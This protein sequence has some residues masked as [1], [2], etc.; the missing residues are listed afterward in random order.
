MK[1]FKADRIVSF[2]PRQIKLFLSLGFA[3]IKADTGV[4]LRILASIIIMKKFF[5]LKP[6]SKVYFKL[7]KS[8]KRINLEIRKVRANI[9]VVHNYTSFE[10]VKY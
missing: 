8:L 10:K 9:P 7:F 1:M 3:V 5:E 4:F 2:S 6:L